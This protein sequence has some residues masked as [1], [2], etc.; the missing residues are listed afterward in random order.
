MIVGPNGDARPPA[1]SPETG[2]HA[3]NTNAPVATEIA[4]P[5]Q[6]IARKRV[7]VAVPNAPASAR[8]ARRNELWRDEPRLQ[9]VIL[10]VHVDKRVAFDLLQFGEQRPVTIAG[11]VG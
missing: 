8:L 2:H 10:N 3:N 4:K 11:P 7:P 5:V 1:Q 9:H 6:P